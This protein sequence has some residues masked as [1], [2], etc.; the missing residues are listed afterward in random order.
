MATLQATCWLVKDAALPPFLLNSAGKGKPLFGREPLVDV[1]EVFLLHHRELVL[2]LRDVELLRERR[3]PILD[4][5]SLQLLILEHLGGDLR[6]Q[7][8]QI[9]VLTEGVTSVELVVAELARVRIGVLGRPVCGEEDLVVVRVH[10]LLRSGGR[11]RVLNCWILLNWRILKNRIIQQILCRGSSAWIYLQ[12]FRE[13]L[14]SFWRCP[15][16]NLVEFSALV[17]SFLQVETHLSS[18]SFAFLPVQKFL[19]TQGR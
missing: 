14:Q 19:R 7:P 6:G 12:H 18:K 1:G 13:Y 8:L 3:L 15:R 4:V 10:L 9:I 2:I 11:S 17:D 5:R 16:H